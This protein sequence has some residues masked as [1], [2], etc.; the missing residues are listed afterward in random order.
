[1]LA[2]FIILNKM[3]YLDDMLAALVKQ[4]VRGATILDSKGLAGAVVYQEMES[5][6]LFGTFRKI[7][8]GAH[9]FNN[10][11]FTVVSKDII[12]SVTKAVQDV[13]SGVKHPGAG[14][15][16]TVPVDGIYDL[17]YKEKKY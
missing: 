4:G 8:E 11:I 9:P 10:T 5:I 17:G 7:F 2:L 15:M 3:N 12:N 1:M 6:P 14:F 13:L 16:F